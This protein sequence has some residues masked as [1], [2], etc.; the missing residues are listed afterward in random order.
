MNYIILFIIACVFLFR[1]LIYKL[2]YDKYDAI[3]LDYH[4]SNTHVRYPLYQ[5]EIFKNG[6][7][8]KYE[9]WGISNFTPKKGKKYKILVHKN[10]HN[11]VVAYNEYIYSFVVGIIFI[12]WN[13]IEFI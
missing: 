10:K 11:K 4:T 13:F 12:L 8:V 7:M 9:S 6:N 1:A 3:C 2:Y 5:Y